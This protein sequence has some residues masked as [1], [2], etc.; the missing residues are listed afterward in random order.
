MSHWKDSW[1]LN[2]YILHMIKTKQ[3]DSLEFQAMLRVYGREKL[4]KIW[5][6]GR[7]KITVPAE[8]KEELFELTGRHR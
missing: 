2:D 6:E 4:E 1:T 5:K 8:R 3:T 7:A